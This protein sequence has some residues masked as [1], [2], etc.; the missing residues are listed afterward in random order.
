MKAAATTITCRRR[1]PQRRTTSRRC[2]RAP[3]YDGFARY[4]FRVPAV[5]VSPSS[6]PDHVTSV[7][8]DHTSIL[9]TV[10]RKWNLPAMT[11][12]DAP[13]ADLS[14]F[15]DLDAPAFAE[16]PPLAKPRAGHAQTRCEKTG[17]GQISPPGSVS[18]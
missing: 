17:P 18:R 4:G 5:V 10:E 15:L 16:P 2:H 1:R 3:R 8:H 11:G 14:D 6:R 7:V 13:A 12:R 9:A